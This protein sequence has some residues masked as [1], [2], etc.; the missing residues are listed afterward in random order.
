MDLSRLALKNLEDAVLEAPPKVS[1][2]AASGTKVIC[3]LGPSSQ[4]VN[5]LSAILCAGMNV[6]RFDF[7]G[8]TR[9]YHQ[10]TMDNLRLASK[11]ESKLV[12]TML[13]TKGPEVTVLNRGEEDLIISAGQAVEI[14]TDSSAPATSSCLP[15]S[16]S[17]IMTAVRAGDKV[18]LSQYLAT[19]SES[20][21]VYL[22][23]VAVSAT[24]VSCTALNDAVM[25]GKLLTLRIITSMENASGIGPASGGDA[26]ATARG[27]G[28]KQ[29][30]TAKLDLPSLTENDKL[31][32]ASFGKDNN[33]DFI[34][35]S[36]TQ[37][38][39]AVH[40]CRAF[41]TANGMGATK[42]MA[43]VENI[44]GLLNYAEILE[45]AD[46]VIISRGDLGVDIPA[47]KMFLI[48]KYVVEMANRAGK[49]V[50][51][52]R[53]VDS[54]TENPRPTR[55]EAT[56]VANI[57]L[58]SADGI[59]LGAETFR[60]KFPVDAVK[61]V[62][63]ICKEAEA[64][65]DNEAH[66]SR[67]MQ[68]HDLHIRSGRPREAL[69]RVEAIASSAV[70]AATKVKASL[71]I[72]ITEL[73]R[74]SRMVAKYRPSM[75]VMAVV[76]PHVHT[77]G[78]SWYY[79]G[80]QEAR[81]SLLVRGVIPVMS[82]DRGAA[83]DGARGGRGTSHAAGGGGIENYALVRAREL[84]LVEEGDIV[85]I[86]YAC[87][88]F[89]RGMTV[90]L[91]PLYVPLTIRPFV[92]SD[93]CRRSLHRAALGSGRTALLNFGKWATIAMRSRD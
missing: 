39:A 24:S 3:S 36:F 22:T 7:S 62:L 11:R 76:V 60:G 20:S 55:A 67:I 29:L 53:V 57:V 64:T 48:Q 31:D 21:S 89:A 65:F 27:A 12:A 71:I 87:P 81:Q 32:I 37:D 5:V 61:T 86:W 33:V 52:T 85:V 38:A 70:R 9:E 51:I 19:G 79:T 34:S 77:D 42:V 90:Y 6:A 14:V 43:K 58:G 59:L 47:E 54:M 23:V 88:I 13:D 17:K 40:E 69:S 50:I 30:G 82:S 44:F 56:D 73:G 35:L 72:V 93:P 75:P 8:A 74:T 41:L 49:P 46:G 68:M 80:E 15:V 16:Y 18:Y 45:A 92:L 84:G 91:T 26:E 78:L 83:V 28:S 63:S 25:K 10:R 1:H 66:F 2:Y 4:E